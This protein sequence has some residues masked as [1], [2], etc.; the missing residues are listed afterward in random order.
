[1]EMFLIL[2]LDT[3][4]QESKNH[5]LQPHDTKYTRKLSHGESDYRLEQGTGEAWE[6]SFVE[7]FKA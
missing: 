1:M 5:S 4:K 3:E 7:I 2:E 6:S